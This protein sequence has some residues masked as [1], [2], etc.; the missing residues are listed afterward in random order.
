MIEDL[1]G[2][3]VEPMRRRHVVALSG[4]VAAVSLA[5]LFVLVAPR[6]VAMPQASSPAPSPVASFTLTIATNPMNTVYVDPANTSL[7]PDWTSFVLSYVVSFDPATGRAYAVQPVPSMSRSA[8]APMVADPRTGRPIVWS[9][10]G[11]SGSA[12]ATFIYDREGRY[13]VTCATSKG[14]TPPERLVRD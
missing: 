8:P 10:A 9:S 1:E 11:T 5:L 7:C 12:P 3:T 2:A 14:I 6:E 4:A 13:I